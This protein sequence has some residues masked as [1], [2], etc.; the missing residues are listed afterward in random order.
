MDLEDE[1]K[2][3]KFMKS[4]NKWFIY[5]YMFFFVIGLNATVIGLRIPDTTAVVGDIINIPVY[6]DT[7]LTGENI[8]SYQFQISFETNNVF[9][10][11]VF[12]FLSISR[13]KA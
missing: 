12:L 7:S 13:P 8:Y 2:I 1:G 5:F 9:A 3:K 11:T 10:T 6:A 4:K